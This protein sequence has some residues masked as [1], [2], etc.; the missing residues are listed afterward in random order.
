MTECEPD[1]AASADENTDL[2]TLMPET[3]RKTRLEHWRQKL[4]DFSLRNR[5]LNAKPGSHLVKLFVEDLA[6]IEDAVSGNKTFT[7]TSLEEKLEPE[8][9]KKFAAAPEAF[10]A[11]EGVLTLDAKE[12]VEGAVAENAGNEDAGADIPRR[13]LDLAAWHGALAQ[14]EKKGRMWCVAGS[15]ELEKRL[16][17]IYRQAR[18]DIEEGGVNTLFLALG[19]LCWPLKDKTYKAPLL[20]LPL[21]MRRN[22]ARSPMEISRLDEDMRLNVTL[23]EMLRQLFQ[24]EIPGLDPLPSDEHGVDLAKVL[25]VFSAA[26]KDIP[27]FSVT[28]E[29]HLGI[30]SFS[31]FIMWNDLTHRAEDLQ[32]NPLVK[33]LI[34]GGGEYDDGVAVFPPEAIE[35]NLDIADLYCPLAADASQLTAVRYAALGKSFVLHGPPG[36]GKSQTIA[37]LIADNLARGRRVLFVS[38]KKAALDVVHRRLSRIG[39]KPFCLELHSHKGGKREVLDQFKEALEFTAS[40]PPDGWGE[41]A[42]RLGK[43]RD[44]LAGYVGDLHYVYPNGLSVYRCFAKLLGRGVNREKNDWLRIDCL[45]QTAEQLATL[46]YSLNETLAAFNY[47]PAAVREIFAPL[48]IFPHSAEAE[49]DLRARAAA[50]ADCG[51]KLTA[52]LQNVWR[53]FGIDIE[54]DLPP[55]SAAAL[56]ECLAAAVPDGL[57]VPDFPEQKEKLAAAVAVGRELQAELNGKLRTYRPEALDGLDADSLRERLEANAQKFFLRRWLADRALAKELSGIKKTGAAALC[58]DD[59]RRDLPRIAAYQSLRGESLQN[60]RLAEKMFGDLWQGENSPW[61]DLAAALAGAEKIAD[62][63]AALQK[64][65]PESSQEKIWAGF[66]ARAVSRRPASAALAEAVKEFARGLTELA[67]AAHCA[68]TDFTAAAGREKGIAEITAAARALADNAGELRR[69]CLWKRQRETAVKEGLDGFIAALEEGKFAPEDG[70]EVFVYAY[71]ARMAEQALAACPRLRDFMGS[72]QDERVRA[73]RQINDRY[74]ALSRDSA[75]AQTAAA[76][77]ETLLDKVSKNSELG[78]LRHECEKKMRHK[79]VRRLLELIPR[80]AVQL[81][82]CF[83]MSPL[84]VAQYLPP[85]GGG[86]GDFDLVV[87][88][89]ASQIPVWD[90]IG[91]IARG[92][93]LIV[94]GDQKQMPPTN[95]FQKGADAAEDDEDAGDLESVLDECMAAGMAS[96][97]LQWHYRSRHESLIAFSNHH[98]YG[99]K[100]HTFPAARNLP[101]LGV[102]HHFVPD[103]PYERARRVNR[104]EA[105]AVVAHIV[106]RLQNPETASKSI[107]VVTFSQAQKDL[108]EDLLEQERAAHP[109]LDKYFDDELPEPLF[110][111]NLENVQGDERD[112]ILF[113][114]G[115]APDDK[116]VFYM[117]FGPLN[118]QGGERRLNVAITRAKE[119]VVVFASV[120]SSR[121]DLGRT[122]AVGAAHLKA[123]LEY[124]ERAEAAQSARA[125]GDCKDAETFAASSVKKE[126]KFFAPAVAEFLRAHGYKAATDIGRGA[127]KIDVAV[128]HPERPG[129]YVIGIEC[130][131]AAYCAAATV[132]DREVTRVSVL[133]GLGWKMHRLWITEWWHDPATAREKLLNAVKSALAE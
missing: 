130:D 106:E 85:D 60:S 23:V 2:A 64:I 63:L 9:W 103:S 86:F 98:Y 108:L 8:F 66:A 19:A 40:P 38:E 55:A 94:V 30:F 127:Y 114:I 59:L 18:T 16:L 10:A 6:G 133:S 68:E 82:P 129:E 116:D 126:E 101:W 122:S 112:V 77:P 28:G 47:V 69:V 97:Y 56:A 62:T 105:S 31:K 32:H 35:K 12:K 37:N 132:R 87:F 83:L 111:K 89:E 3:A 26:V 119:Q 7:V 84:S 41:T 109:E 65:L 1:A 104:K 49:N 100:L 45:T 115:Y 14:E 71:Y 4:L 72:T 51:E 90:A 17:G 91:V 58:A 74:T 75:I 44:E 120:S 70:A 131:G 36:T 50:L 80:L 79:P 13:E 96:S 128:E 52:A 24:L 48:G 78:I 22:S 92:K 61:D 107:G 43:L 39:L 118:R 121:I 15:K 125:A 34:A 124:A 21:T 88:D 53:G 102:R 117:N 29:A 113:S 110:V 99:D 81:K 42:S 5:L 57:V 46:R 33:H 25:A 67:A 27:G 11:R 95:F 73:F 54:A 20:L 93:Q 76:R 123:F